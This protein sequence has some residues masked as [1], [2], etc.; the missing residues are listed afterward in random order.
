[1]I[2]MIAIRLV[3]ETDAPSVSRMSASE[4]NVA[5]NHL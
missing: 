2:A 4:Q 3:K 5:A 1:M